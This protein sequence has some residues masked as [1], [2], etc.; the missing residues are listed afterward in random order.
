[1]N[2]PSDSGNIAVEL[3]ALGLM[4]PLLI[5]QTALGL[6]QQQ[7]CSLAAEQLARESVRFQVSGSLTPETLGLLKTEVSGELGL[8]PSEISLSVTQPGPGEIWEA[9]ATIGGQTERA[10]MRQ[11]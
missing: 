6:F 10:R 3:L 2:R 4:A 5:T 9:E 1:M 7:R 8:D 11:Q